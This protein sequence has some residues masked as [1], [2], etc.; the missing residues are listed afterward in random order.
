MTLLHLVRHGQA[1]AGFDADLD[2]GLDDVGRAQA[3]Q[4]A[5]QLVTRGPLS[6]RTSPLR[7]CQETAAPL[8]SLWGATALV[9]PAVTEVAAPTADLAGRAAWLRRAMAGSW[10]E[11]EEAPQTWRRTLLDGLASLEVETVVF[12]HFVAINAVIGAAT[13]DDRVLVERI[14]NGSVTTVEV[15]P[16]GIELVRSGET[17]RST[18][19]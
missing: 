18:V 9:D 10:S 15:G 4:V 17:G 5:S 14:A 16:D 6:V 7:R 2:P 12:T 11:L 1:A 8:C 13:G 3:V 19:L